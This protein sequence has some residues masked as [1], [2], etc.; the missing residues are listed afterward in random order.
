MAEEINAGF[1]QLPGGGLHGAVE[2]AAPD[3]ALGES[4]WGE[5]A[6]VN[7]PVVD[8]RGDVKLEYDLRR[9][10]ENC[11]MRTFLVAF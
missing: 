4:V 3:Q 10:W 7:V 11:E 6:D 1:S 2:R 5:F 8:Y 9:D